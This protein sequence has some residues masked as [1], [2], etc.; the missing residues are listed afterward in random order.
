LLTVCRYVALNPVEAGLAVHP[1][2]WPWSS[3]SATAGL[4][5]SSLPLDTMP[6]KAALGDASDWQ[7]RY[8][9]FITDVDAC[10]DSA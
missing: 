6:L 8:R 7:M 2:D 3:C 10:L 1:F 4:G 5:R 9:A